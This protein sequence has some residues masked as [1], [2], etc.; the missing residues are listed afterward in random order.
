MQ[1]PCIPTAPRHLIWSTRREN[2][3]R[4]FYDP[5]AQRAALFIATLIAGRCCVRI[6][7]TQPGSVRNYRLAERWVVYCLINLAWTPARRSA[8]RKRRADPDRATN[9]ASCAADRQ[10]KR[11]QSMNKI[12]IIQGRCKPPESAAPIHI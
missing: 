10:N 6:A 5:I 1:A 4:E 9:A 12:V 8:H 11:P 2:G 7:Y 3:A